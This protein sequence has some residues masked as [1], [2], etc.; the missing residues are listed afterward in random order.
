[1]EATPN[2]DGKP[3]LP[4]VPLP[5]CPIPTSPLVGQ[6]RK[7]RKGGKGEE[8]DEGEEEGSI[9]QRL[10]PVP[11]PSAGPL[12]PIAHHHPSTPLQGPGGPPVHP[13]N[14]SPGVGI[15]AADAMTLPTLISGMPGDATPSATSSDTSET[16]PSAKRRRVSEPKCLVT[17]YEEDIKT[18]YASGKFKPKQIRDRIVKDH[19]LDPE[20]LTAEAVRKKIGRLI[21]KGVLEKKTLGTPQRKGDRDGA[22]ENGKGTPGKR[23]GSRESQ[24]RRG[25]TDTAYMLSSLGKFFVSHEAQER[26][27]LAHIKLCGNETMKAREFDHDRF[28]IDLTIAP[29]SKH[30]IS[31]GGDGTQDPEPHVMLLT[32]TPPAGERFDIGR[33]PERSVCDLEGRVLPQAE[34]DGGAG[35][36]EG[37]PQGCRFAVLKFFLEDKGVK[38]DFHM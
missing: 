33:H 4:A 28:D 19:G 7:R 15:G 30:V 5:S 6:K 14:A 24:K 18:H 21:E 27:M 10:L 29:P 20:K 32:I 35:P 23:S 12:P 31:Y 34:C 3:S 8:G 1:M 2:S 36:M 17:R 37:V 38:V 9:T 11:E 13:Q 26:V 22:R 16:P 25:S